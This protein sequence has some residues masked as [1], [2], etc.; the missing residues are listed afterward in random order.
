M[1]VHFLFSNSWQF[2]QNS[3]VDKIIPDYNEIYS[4]LVSKLSRSEP[5]KIIGELVTINSLKGEVNTTINILYVNHHHHPQT[6]RAIP[7][8]RPK[9]SV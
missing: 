2:S 8:P 9:V 3:L 5:E 7:P 1:Y 6:I 4:N